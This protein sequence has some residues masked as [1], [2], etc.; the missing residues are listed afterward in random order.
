MR[1]SQLL[2]TIGLIAVLAATGCVS[3]D[4]PW[5]DDDSAGEENELDELALDEPREPKPYTF[6]IDLPRGWHDVHDEYV[7]DYPGTNFDGLW[8]AAPSYRDDETFASASVWMYPTDSPR[9]LLHDESTKWAEEF[10]EV[11]FGD[12]EVR[13]TESGGSVYWQSVTGETEGQRMTM[14]PAYVFHGPYFLFVLVEKGPDSLAASEGILESLTSVEFSGPVDL[15]ERAGPPSE[16]DGR[17]ASYCNTVSVAAQPAWVYDFTPRYDVRGIRCDE[18][19]DYL[20]SWYVELDGVPHSVTSDHFL[21]STVDEIMTAN[22]I[23]HEVGVPTA[24]ASGAIHTLERL[25]QLTRSD[26]VPVTWIQDRIEFDDGTVSF[27]QAIFIEFDTGVVDI[28]IF[29]RADAFAEDLSSVWDVVESI[30]VSGGL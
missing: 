24:S 4:V 14:T 28:G 16:I 17:W 19:F 15:S 8:E 21:G 9:A 27:V 2:R 20:G 6:A 11:T 22:A 13:Q 1:T 7:Q 29:T 18:S 23:P 5:A 3:T 25:D 26:G 30:Q 10:E 12:L